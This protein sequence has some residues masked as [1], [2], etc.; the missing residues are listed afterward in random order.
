MAPEPAG[1][2]VRIPESDE[3]GL[4]VLGRAARRDLPRHHRGTPRERRRACDDTCSM[5]APTCEPAFVHGP[6]RGD[7]TDG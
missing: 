6:A 2:H 3:W 7:L 1:E 4:L 5:P